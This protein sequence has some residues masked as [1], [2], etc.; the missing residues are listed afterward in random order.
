MSFQSTTKVRYAPAQAGDFASAN[1]RW[2]VLAGPGSLVAAA[3]GVVIGRFAW[4]ASTGSA[5]I[6][7]GETDFYNTVSNAGSGAPTGF[8]HR[9]NQALITTFLAE[10]GYTIP[11]GQM[12]TLSSGGDFWVKNDGASAVTAG[13]KVFASNTTGQVQTGAAGATIAGYT[14]TKW[15]AMSAA[16]AGE[17]FKMSSHALG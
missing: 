1:P 4:A 6:E 8:V 7:T 10:A 9:E 15:Y 14:E 13:Q 16:A 2:S 5:D 12:V 17:L 11:Q 3:A